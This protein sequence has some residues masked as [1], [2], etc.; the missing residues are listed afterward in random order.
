MP[1]DDATRRFSE[2]LQKGHGRIDRRHIE[3]LTPLKKTLNFAHVAQVFRVRRERTD[4]KSGEQSIE[5]AYGITSLAA[6]GATP[7]QLLAWNRGHWAI[8][9]KNHHRRD[10]TLCEDAC[11]ARSGLAP[12]NRATC[13][14]IVLALILGGTTP[15]RPCATSHYAGAK[16]SRRCSRPAEAT[17]ARHYPS[18]QRPRLFPITAPRH[19]SA[20]F[21]H[22][23]LI[24]SAATG[25][26]FCCQR[27]H[28][29][30]PKPPLHPSFPSPPPVS[31][32]CRATFLAMFASVPIK[33]QPSMGWSCQLVPVTCNIE[34]RCTSSRAARPKRVH[35][36]ISALSDVSNPFG[37]EIPT[38]L[39]IR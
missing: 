21:R 15:R 11:T 29:T 5:Y 6:E 34:L 2:D 12:A 33:T 9:S 24:P 26:R 13:N 31:V 16:P 28:R 23:Y 1:W 39:L 3:V 8:E 4:L 17:P 22:A 18:A 20:R 38:R 36:V 7:Q 32:T 30:S 25:M 14:N 27:C 35:V 37:R 10:K 19:P